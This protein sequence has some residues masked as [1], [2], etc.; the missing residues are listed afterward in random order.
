MAAFGTHGL[1]EALMHKCLEKHDVFASEYI[2]DETAQH[3]ADKFGF[4]PDNVAEAVTFM[5]AEAQFVEPSTI[6][7]DACRDPKDIPILGTAQAAEAD[8]LVTGDKDLLVL[9]HFGK[10]KIISPRQFYD[11]LRE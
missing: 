4:S 9:R 1:C 7:A 11:M 10:T 6:S 5:R 2:L 3:L 8:Y